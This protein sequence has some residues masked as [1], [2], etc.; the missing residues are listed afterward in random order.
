MKEVMETSADLGLQDAENL[1]AVFTNAD[2]ATEL[3]AVMD[4]AKE[5]LG[6]DD[7][8]GK[9]KLDEGSA[10]ILANTLKNAD[11]A[12][13]MK[14]VMEVSADLGLQDSDTLTSVFTNADKIEDLKAVMDVAKETLGTDDGTGTK[15]LDEGSAAILANTLKNADKAAEMKEVMEVSADLGLQDSDTLT[16]VFTNADKIEDLKA[17]MDVAKET[18]GTDDGTGKKKLDEGSAAILANTLKNADKAAEM[19]EVMEVSADLGLQDSDTLT[20]VFTNADKIDDL[21]AV[22][23]VAKESIGTDDGT[24]VKKLD[25]SKASFLADTLRNADKATQYRKVTDQL[26]DSSVE[27]DQNDVFSNLDGVSETFALIESEDG[28]IDAA[29]AANL[30]AGAKDIEESK[31]AI[32]RA[33]D[34]GIDAVEIAKKDVEEQRAINSV[35]EKLQE[36]GGADAANN[37]LSS[38]AAEDALQYDL[39]L[40]DDP[41][42]A[43][44]IASAVTDISGDGESALPNVDI[45]AKIQEKVT[46]STKGKLVNEYQD[47]D[48][49]RSI[50]E[51]NEARAQDISFALSFVEKE[52]AQEKA[53]F[54]NIDKLDS[55]MV[56]GRFFKDD[57]TKLEIVFNNLDHANSLYLL[58][59]EFKN[60]PSKIDLVL[61]NPELSPAVLSAYNDFKSTGS[62]ALISELFADSASMRNTLAN[63]GINKLRQKY[64]KYESDLENYS[65][66][67]GEIKGLLEQFEGNSDRESFILENLE[68]FDAI[69]GFAARFEGSED[70]LDMV[71]NYQGNIDE[72]KT[73]SDELKDANVIGGQDFLFDNL[74]R[75]DLLEEQIQQ[76]PTFIELEDQ[77]DSDAESM[78]IVFSNPEKASQLL[79]LTKELENKGGD[80]LA[81][82]D[83][84]D[85]IE[86]L[87]GEFGNDAEKMR[88]VFAN[89]EKAEKLRNLSNDLEGKGGDLLANIDQLDVIEDLAGEFGNDAEKMGVVFAN[90]EKAEKLRNL[91]NDLEGKG[92]DLL[93]NIDQLDVI[94]ELAINFENDAKKMGVVFENIQKIDQISSIS[95]RYPNKSDEILS[96]VDNLTEVTSLVDRFESDQDKIE[97][98]FD[99]VDRIDD[100][101][102]MADKFDLAREDGYAVGAEDVIENLEFLDDVLALDSK[103]EEEDAKL[104]NLYLNPQKAAE[105]K[106]FIDKYGESA[107]DLIF[108]L[109]ALESI[110]SLEDVYKD[111]SQKMLEVLEN[112]DKAIQLSALTNA[113]EG[114]ERRSVSQYR[115]V[116]C[117]RRFGK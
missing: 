97:V 69:R 86:D 96:A 32:Q 22:M 110:S 104:M 2:K 72:L 18:L 24:G 56:L 16:S 51:E 11:K 33:K 27:I 83:Q 64:T 42:L 107:D 17:V 81:N 36:A 102:T 39:A 61:E 12:A 67:A 38:G 66:R 25:S 40:N 117:D 9:K 65:D 91:S 62:D 98:L 3:K 103:F 76:I 5:T 90:S 23:D 4:V 77:F 35:V 31:K 46:D 92:G 19:K 54:A 37:F 105:L 78:N 88:V 95:K 47:N 63:D 68:D 74:D 113:L 60:M 34:A 114:K 82:I 75:L 109:D 57:D 84:L 30:I 20:S 99:N 100:I 89:S 59:E 93:A 70:K 28:T 48:L 112:A 49:Y 73:V 26:K 115:S 80:L 58:V 111:D 116:G 87:A 108:N 79:N 55:I 52:S 41:D 101:K 29:A 71:F 45:K 15:K 8:T 85:V 43:G 106:V 50:I 53:L 14:E 1:T 6:T 13:E 21:K 7:G 10:S 44:A 94:E